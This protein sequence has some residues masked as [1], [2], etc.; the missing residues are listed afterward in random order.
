M[1]ITT[2]SLFKKSMFKELKFIQLIHFIKIL[3]MLIFS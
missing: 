2:Q 3:A 1:Q